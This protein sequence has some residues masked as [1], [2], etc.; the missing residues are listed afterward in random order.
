[1]LKE[2][3]K[4]DTSLSEQKPGHRAINLISEWHQK[5]TFDFTEIVNDRKLRQEI[6]TA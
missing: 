5:I 4:H 6:V 3:C 2:R 1:M